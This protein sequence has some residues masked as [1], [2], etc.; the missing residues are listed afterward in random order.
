MSRGSGTQ[1]VALLASRAI[2]PSRVPLVGREREVEQIVDLLRRAEVRVVTVTGP[3]GI[4]KTVVAEAA[5]RI[6]AEQLPLTVQSIALPSGTRGVASEALA[7]AVSEVASPAGSPVPAGRRRLVL[8]DGA[9]TCAGAAEAISAALDRDPALSILATSVAPLG[10]RGEHVVRL[11]PLALPPRASRDVAAVAA[12]PATQLF[13]T[14]LEASDP[15]FELTAVNVE[16]VADLCRRLDGYPLALELAAARCATATVAAVSAQLDHT[17]SL[18]V[19]QRDSSGVTAR[20][21]SLRETIEWSVGM[22]DDDQSELLRHLGAFAGSFTWDALVAIVAAGDDRAAA[23]LAPVLDALVATGIVRR[24]VDD[25]CADIPRYVV[26]A[27]VHE[28]VAELATDPTHDD[29]LRRRHSR[30]YRE[31]ARRAAARQWSAERTDAMHELLAEQDGLLQAFDE[32]CGSDDVVAALELAV[33]LE[34]LW[35]EIGANESAAASLAQL[36][37]RARAA[38]APSAP[39]PSLVVE[40]MTA[41]AALTVWTRD[42][43]LGAVH[44]LRLAETARLARALDRPDLL[45]RTMVTALQTELV[46]GNYAEARATVDEAIALAQALSDDWCRMRILSLSAA[47][48]NQA[49]DPALAVEHGIAARDL[50]RALGDE[51]QLVLTSHVLTGIREANRE[52][53][54][55]LPSPGDLLAMARRLG[56]VRVEGMVLISTAIRHAMVKDLTLA[57]ADLRA[58]LDLARRNGFWYIEELALFALVPMAVMAGHDAEAA[59]LSGALHDVITETRLHIAPGPVAAYDG[60]LAAAREA[61][62]DAAFDRLA[63]GGRLHGWSE[64]LTVADRLVADLLDDGETG[65]PHVMPVVDSHGLTRASSTCCGRCRAARRTRTSPGRWGYGRRPSCTTPGASTA[66]WA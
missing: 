26:P 65:G 25:R 19:L 20:H 58:A 13:C 57:A 9:E 61:L 11:G 7:A 45:L 50:A 30:Y 35:I 55:E 21:R 3:S 16:L 41:L 23:A 47:A 33:D 14:R 6:L 66:S 40:A 54:A 27:A 34:P 52:V 10:I 24:V 1:M 15:D 59:R 44:H 51:H 17:P 64:A 5:G 42:A 4:G 46:A 43:D 48:A 18:D 63:A 49:G 38:D 31:I 29:E 62:G 12:A 39:D 37:E 56:I 22:L 32:V 53:Q 8:V 2:P 28:L 60:A 36:L